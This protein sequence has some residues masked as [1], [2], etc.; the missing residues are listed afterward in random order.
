MKRV[1][2]LVALLCVL[3]VMALPLWAASTKKSS[4]KDGE[5][6]SA[7]LELAKVATQITGVAISPLLGVSAI[8]AYEWWGASTEA[9]KAA[10]PWFANPMVWIGGFLLVGAAAAKDAFGAATPP[11]WKKPL[12]VLD[13]TENKISGLVATGAVIPVLVSAA[14][15]V[16]AARGTPTA[17][18]ELHFG[19]LAM[20]HLGAMDFSWLLTILMVPLAIAVHVVV[21]IA[22]HA[23]NVLI[24]LSPWGAVDAALKGART[25]VLGLVTGLAFIDPVVGATLSVVIIVLAY[26]LSGWA[27]RLT[28]F[29]T[30]FC[31]DFFTARR[32]RFELLADGNKLFLARKLEGVPLRTYGRLYQAKD[33]ALTFK[34]RPWLVLAE[35]EIPVPRE[36]IVVGRGV[37]YSEVLGHN[38]ATDKVETLL[39]LPP[40]YVGHEELFARTYRISGTCEVGLRKAWSWL[41]E[42]LGFGKKAATPATAAA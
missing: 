42:A 36:G 28:V 40:R 6:P 18:L 35:R 12:D 10:L 25:A 19:N 29:G 31:W 23:I 15:K 11:G 1:T 2:P 39:L 4:G 16:M 24:L 8:G 9:E 33:G 32:K 3:S 26:F 34:F 41:K 13:A 17:G 30:V 27:F 38:S 22:S 5:V 7:G 21:W 14:S 20:V 37:F